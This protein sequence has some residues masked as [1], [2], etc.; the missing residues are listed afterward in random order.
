[1]RQLG[2]Q[3]S[4]RID[5]AAR[6]HI[7]IAREEGTRMYT[8]RRCIPGTVLATTLVASGAELTLMHEQ[9][10]DVPGHPD[11]EPWDFTA[12]LF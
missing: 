3:Q 7:E 12:D 10:V 4:K 6:T 1:M 9:A 2:V 8:D 5:S 11:G